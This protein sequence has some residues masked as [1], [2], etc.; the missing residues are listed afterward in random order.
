MDVGV[1]DQ[2]HSPSSVIAWPENSWN[3][4]ADESGNTQD[5]SP[6][7]HTQNMHLPGQKLSFQDL[8]LGCF[9]FPE[10]AE[11]GTVQLW[12]ARSWEMGLVRT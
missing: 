12:G 3:H 11:M 1:G 9:L 10:E 4:W 5:V 2:L 8:S 6:Q 7:L